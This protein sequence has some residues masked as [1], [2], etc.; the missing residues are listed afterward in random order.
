MSENTKQIEQINRV[1][2][3]LNTAI[4][5]IEKKNNKIIFFVPDTKG[6]ARSSV[7][8]IY[9]TAETLVELGYNVLMLYNKNDYMKP[10]S[11]GKAEYD[12]IPIET[13]ENQTLKVGPE[14]IMVISEINGTILQETEQLPLMRVIYIQSHEYMLDTFPFGKTWSD[15][16]VFNAI[17][18]SENIVDLIRDVSHIAQIDVV[19]P[20]VGDKFKPTNKLKKP[21]VAIYSREQ[22]KTAKIIKQFTTM[23]PLYRWV[24]FRDA[25]GFNH[26]DL[27]NLLA[28]SMVAVWD[29]DIA[30]Y[31]RFALEALK[32]NTPVIA[33]LPDI[34]QDWM[35]NDNGIWVSDDNRIAEICAAYI[36]RWIE[37]DASEL[38]NVAET[39]KD[40]GTHDE[41]L[42]SV[43]VAFDNLTKNRI[44][45]LRA[46]IDIYQEQL[47][48]LENVEEVDAEV[49]TNK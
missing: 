30:T 46:N 20:K 14:D 8:N 17:T 42:E 35:S 33:K 41:H 31:G 38:Q 7:I 43:K 18:C 36:K 13:I 11:W 6:Q 9:D 15:F 28:E 26:E 22:R 34:P 29:D 19:K 32:T 25:H 37:D 27:P 21:M 2:T 40:I 47:D 3:N 10:S 45:E 16:G 48:F 4:D 23:Y 24:S 44:E 12:N 1:L 39:V 5:N 49:I